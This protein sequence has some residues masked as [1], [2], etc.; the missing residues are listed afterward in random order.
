[1]WGRVGCASHPHPES[2]SLFLV[3]PF[4]PPPGLQTVHC[5]VRRSLTKPAYPQTPF[6]PAGSSP[7]RSG[8]VPDCFLPS[9]RE[10]P[11]TGPPPSQTL[12]Q[13]CRDKCAYITPRPSAWHSKAPGAI[14]RGPLLAPRS[15][16]RWKPS[17]RCS[18]G[19]AESRQNPR[20]LPECGDC[21]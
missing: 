21:R 4:L 10:P 16:G 1:M 14:R 15:F 5:P 8:P 9:D 12:T 7:Q 17:P 19:W 20:S 3:G 6:I 13:G 11:T 2:L 18:P